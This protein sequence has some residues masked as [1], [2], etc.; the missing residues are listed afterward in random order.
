MNTQRKTIQVYC[1][2]KQDSSIKGYWKDNTGKVYIDNIII[3]RYTP[4]QFL[5]IKAHLFNSGELAI[6]YIVD[7]IAYIQSK[8]TIQRLTRRI[9]LD[10][11]QADDIQ[12]LLDIYGG[13][14]YFTN[15]KQAHIWQE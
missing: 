15:T 13:L 1:P 7:D 9:V 2:I 4:I 8:D 3:S 5:R 14:T 11:I 6:F 10:D 12:G